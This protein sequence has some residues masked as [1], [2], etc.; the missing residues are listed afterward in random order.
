MF[1]DAYNFITLLHLNINKPRPEWHLNKK[2]QH[3]NQY[4]KYDICKYY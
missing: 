2:K 4:H 1:I 3:V